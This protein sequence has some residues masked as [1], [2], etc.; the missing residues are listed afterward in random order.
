MTPSTT[1]AITKFSSWAARRWQGVSRDDIAQE[2]TLVA[3]DAGRFD[4][5]Q[6]KEVLRRVT[7]WALPVSVTD[8]NRLAR[9]YDLATIR[10]VAF[11]PTSAGR[12]P[13]PEDL[14]ST[15]QLAARVATLDAAILAAEQYAARGLPRFIREMGAVVHEGRYYGVYI[16]LGRRYGIPVTAV[17]A[18]LGR[19]RRAAERSREVRALRAAMEE[20]KQEVAS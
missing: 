4:G 16:D 11:E 3:L 9:G 7:H 20:L 19:Y 13:S 12:A 5:F 17:V 1:L 2:A 18:A 6:R 15:A 10:A 14:V 8:D